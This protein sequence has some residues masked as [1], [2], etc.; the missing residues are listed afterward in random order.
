MECLSRVPF[1]LYANGYETPNPS[2][3]WKIGGLHLNAY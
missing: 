3:L 1:F 2:I